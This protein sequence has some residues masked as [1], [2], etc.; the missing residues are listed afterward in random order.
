MRIAFTHPSIATTNLST[1]LTGQ[2]QRFTVQNNLTGVQFDLDDKYT[3]TLK[4]EVP[5]SGTR[6]LLEIVARMEPGVRRVRNELVVLPDQQD[7]KP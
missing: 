2:L 3:V 1:N 4:G 6:K 7:T 5:T